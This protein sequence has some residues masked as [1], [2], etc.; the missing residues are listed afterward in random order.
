MAGLVPFNRKKTDLINT[1]FDEFYNMLDDFFTDGWPFRRSLIGN[2][3]KVDIQEDNKSYFI[4]AELPGV[5]KE[6]VNIEMNDGRLLISINRDEQTEDERKNYI[7]K[8]RRYCSMQRS[9]FLADADNKGINAKLEEG[10]LKII[11]PKIEKPDNTV[12]IDIE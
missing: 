11:V 5:K 12:K 7:H 6:E 1:G 10:I 2:T 4:A 9:V 3:F 8:E